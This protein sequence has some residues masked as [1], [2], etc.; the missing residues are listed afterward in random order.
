MKAISLLLST[1]GLAIAIA[2]PVATSAE[3]APMLQ[4]P[5]EGQIPSLAGAV[6]WLNSQPLTP[7]ALRG[8]VV[9][10]DFWTYTCVNWQRTFPFVR[11]WAHKYE[12]NGLV[13]I[14]VHTPEFEFEKD[15]ANVHRAIKELAVDYPVAVDSNYAI[16]RAFN[17]EAWPAVYFIDAKGHIRGHHFGEGEYAETERTIQQLLAEAGSPGVDCG[18]VSVDPHGLEVAADWNDVRSP[19]SYTGYERAQNFASPGGVVADRAHVYGAP[20]RLRLNQWALSG[21]WTIRKDAAALNKAN[22]RIAYQFHGRDVNLIMGPARRGS[23]VRFR[24]FIDGEPPGN[25]HGDDVDA[26]GYGEVSRQG[27]YQLIRQPKRIVDR[28]F[29][30]EFLESGAEAFDFTFG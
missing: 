4:L 13:V 18:L 21:D 12:P 20:E 23:S 29:E 19:E 7:A 24:V 8:K 11:A 2:S 27:T 28:R 9:L 15:L 5:V 14:G 22:G 10:V 3:D 25:A 17:N 1:I 16:W 6:E 26:N 30:I